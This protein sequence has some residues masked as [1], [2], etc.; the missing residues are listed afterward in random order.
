MRRR[1]CVLLLL[2]LALSWALRCAVA[3]NAKE[4]QARQ[5]AI[6]S[7]L[8]DIVSEDQKLRIKAFERLRELGMDG[9]RQLVE[10][11]PKLG[12]GND[13][14]VRFAVH[15]LAM[16]FTAKG[17]ERERKELSMTLCDLLK[18][19]LPTWVKRFLIEQLQIV[20]GEEAVE[21]LSTL[22][23][24]EELAESSR[25]ALCA[26]PSES[27]L[28]ALRGWLPKAKGDLRIGIIN[29]LGERRDKNA[30]KLLLNETLSKDRDVRC[31]ALEALG[32]IGDPSAVDA[33]LLGLKDADGRVVR[34]AFSALLM[35][36]ENLLASGRKKEALKA[37]TEALRVVKESKQRRA[38][39]L[40]IA[41]IADAGAIGAIATCLSDKDPYV[42]SLAMECLSV[43]EGEEASA[44]LAKLMKTADEATR[45]RIVLILGRR[46]DKVATRAL[47][48]ALQ[49]KSD[50]VKVASL[51]ALGKLEEA[52]EELLLKA[53][54]SE[55]EEIHETALKA[56]IALAN[57]RLE[58][59]DREGAV[60]M[61]ATA[62]RVARTV[63]LVREALSG[64]AKAPAEEALI[65]VEELLKEPQ[66]ME[67]ASRA[68]FAIA[69][70]L[71]DAGKRDE[72][73]RMLFKLAAMS[74]PRD[75][76]EAVFAKLRQLNPEVDVSSARGFVTSWWLIG[77][78]KGTDIDAVLPPEKE[79]NLEAPV[80]FEGVELRWFKHRT[81]D[82]DGFVNLYGLLKPNENVSAFM[83]AEIE[84]EKEMDALF[85]LGSDDSIKCWLNGKLVHRYP[86][87]RSPAVDQDVVKV[88][89]QAGL[90]RIL[91]KVVNFGGG[92]CAT[93]RITD[94]DGRPVKFKQK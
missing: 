20:G 18:T 88:H 26:N 68:Y 27:A 56:Y 53:A 74:T 23:S 5:E 67:E 89:L 41:K 33:I 55:V 19:D 6:E 70:S 92:W 94:I 13:G 15:G 30:V 24:D 21:T 57:K 63:E 46:K 31:A 8:K 93:L 51:Q 7:I 10:M 61:F 77:P 25:Q 87:P 40:H 59:G 52:S 76:S 69:T 91:L 14:G 16:T 54:T 1:A 60:K 81:N 32:K 49:D 78:F 11:M 80:K 28:N 50:V 65:T 29:A 3:G 84:V 45:S 48:E 47:N 12:E 82:I 72:A 85:K 58:K 64:I 39:L 43:I 2:A 35:L 42:R 37:G 9:V 73:L 22:L 79:V 75:L 17:M 44:Q 4:P 86:E 71:A 36:Y 34:S 62:T 66:L 83:Y 90:N 38:L